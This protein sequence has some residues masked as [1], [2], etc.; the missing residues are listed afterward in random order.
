MGMS[1]NNYKY[2][3]GCEFAYLCSGVDVFHCESYKKRMLDAIK[4]EVKNEHA[5]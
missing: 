4:R 5:N 3:K 1:D 2:C